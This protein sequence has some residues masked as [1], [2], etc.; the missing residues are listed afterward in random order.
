[1]ATAMSSGSGR[2]IAGG[3]GKKSATRTA[4]VT[5][6]WPRVTKAQSATIGNPITRSPTAARDCSTPHAFHAIATNAGGRPKRTRI[7]SQS[8]I[9]HLNTSNLLKLGLAVVMLGV[10]G[11]FLVRFFRQDDGVSEKIYFYDLS[12]K[13]LFTAAR[14][15]VPP[16]KGINDAVEDGVRAVA[17]STTGNCRD[18]ASL[19]ADFLE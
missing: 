10:A 15:S 14:T 11:F 13:K 9:A 3:F 7:N 18:K 8:A 4:R 16:I 2:M 5:T 12:E 6:E 1:M 17:I 19:R